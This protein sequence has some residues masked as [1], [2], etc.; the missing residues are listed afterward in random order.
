MQRTLCEGHVARDHHRTLL[1]SFDVVLVMLV[2]APHAAIVNVLAV[3]KA[4]GMPPERLRFARMFVHVVAQFRIASPCK[5]DRRSAA[6]PYSV[7]HGLRDAARGNDRSPRRRDDV[8]HRRYSPGQAAGLA[9]A[10]EPRLRRSTERLKESRECVSWSGTGLLYIVRWRASDRF[11]NP[12]KKIGKGAR[13]RLRSAKPLFFSE[14][15]PNR[16]FAHLADSLARL[17][18]SDSDS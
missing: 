11:S 1:V 9:R 2:P 6:D 15:A 17:A 18:S 5:P 3:H 10:P 8:R 13:I 7:R 12:V 4:V 14:T 16:Y